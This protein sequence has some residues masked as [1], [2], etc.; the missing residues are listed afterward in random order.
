MMRGYPQ[1]SISMQNMEA[2]AEPLLRALLLGVALTAVLT[3]A[4]LYFGPNRIA[5][6]ATEARRSTW[7]G[8]RRGRLRCV[9]P[10]M[11]GPT[12]GAISLFCPNC[13]RFLHFHQGRVLKQSYR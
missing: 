11:T 3:A 5:R 2:S 9:F 7:M 12:S 1:P 10:S 8:Q 13:G 6:W 4:N